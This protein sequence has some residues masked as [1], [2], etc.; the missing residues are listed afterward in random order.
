MKLS[1]SKLKSLI[2]ECIVEVLAEGIGSTPTPAKINESVK[3][4]K[5]QTEPRKAKSVLDSIKFDSKINETAAS[6][7]NDPV[8]Q[9]IFSD[10][11]KTT[12][13]EQLNHSSAPPPGS[14]RAAHAAA[15]AD[16]TEL[17]GGSSNWAAL[18]FTDGEKN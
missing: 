16:P 13:Q 14:D 9:S 17:F 1:R 5:K 18:A 10:T 15:A 12:L 4:R 6:L 3:S 11:A 2:K 7:T 8:M